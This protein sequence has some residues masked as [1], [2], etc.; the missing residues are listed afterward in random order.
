MKKPLVG[1]FL[2]ITA[3]SFGQWRPKTGLQQ[4]MPLPQPAPIPEGFARVEGG[5]FVMGSPFNESDRSFAEARHQ[6]T[7]K[8]FI[9]SKYE[10]TQKE[11]REVMGTTVDQQREK[12][13]AKYLFGEDDDCPMYYVNWYEAV[14]YCNKRSLK[15]GLT[16]AYSGSGDKIIRNWNADG[17]RLPMEDEWE[18]AAKGGNGKKDSAVTAYSGSGNVDAVAWYVDNSDVSAHLVGTKAPNSL[19]IYD[20]SGNVAEWCWDWFGNYPSK[21]RTLPLDGY[22]GTRR[23]I[24]GG[25]W[26]AVASDARSSARWSNDPSFRSH[27]VGFRVVRSF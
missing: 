1:I 5:T 14:E 26:F 19:G 17:Y 20:M 7:V 4:V 2:L 18:F 3:L 24:R 12:A 22:E 23:V 16:P 25:S 15:E 27:Y 11:W 8:T 6:V 10:V 9:I 21:A 13:Q